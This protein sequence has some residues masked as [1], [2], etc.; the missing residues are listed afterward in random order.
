MS[1]RSYRKYLRGYQVLKIR[2]V[3]VFSFDH[4]VPDEEYR[5]RDIY[6]IFPFALT[7]VCFP[8][9]NIVDYDHRYVKHDHSGPDLLPDEVS[10]FAV[11]GA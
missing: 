5:H 8:V 3:T 4:I 9:L 2:R 7:A 1:A 11:Q 6:R 10:S